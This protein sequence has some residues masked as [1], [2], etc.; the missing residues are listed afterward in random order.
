MGNQ[1]PEQ[2]L[3]DSPGDQPMLNLRY[4]SGITLIEIVIALAIV[5]MT[6]G[7]GA[8]G[9]GG[10]TTNTQIRAAA[11]SLQNGLK[12]ARSEAIKRDARVRF[13]LV[14]VPAAANCYSS[15]SAAGWTVSLNDVAGKCH[16]TPAEPPALPSLPDPD[17]PYIIQFHPAV[18]SSGSLKVTATESLIIFDGL[19]RRAMVNGKLETISIDLGNPQ[20]GN[21]IANGGPVRCL[22]IAISP[23]GQTKICD[24]ALSSADPKGWLCSDLLLTG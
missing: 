19:G 12:L 3:G 6:L 17:N 4:Q 1:H 15:T 5:S 22:R 10:W 7:M 14:A 8:A 24:P 23:M 21:C 20:A 18:E 13:Q 9:L 16:L 11:E 2:L